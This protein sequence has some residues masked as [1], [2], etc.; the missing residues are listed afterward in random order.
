MHKLLII[1]LNGDPLADKGTLHAGGQ[2]KYILELGRYLVREG[3]KIDVFTIHNKS[4]PTFDSITVDFNVHRFHLPTHR[5]YSYDINE[6]DIRFVSKAIVNY[7]NN[8]NLHYSLILSCYW[9]S[10][11][12][13]IDVKSK[14]NKS[15]LV[16]FC[17]LGHFKY[18]LEFI[19]K[20]V[21]WRIA[22]EMKVANHAD[23]IIATSKEERNV[24]VNKYGINS[25]KISII[26]RGVDINVFYKY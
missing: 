23:H 14:I 21:G 26:P 7:I 12:V 11:L 19:S 5:D 15:L 10:G 1:S 13:G 16:T 22:M 6:S 4:K 8:E 20:S 17:S 3:W 18:E 25:T 9:I 2:V 24:L